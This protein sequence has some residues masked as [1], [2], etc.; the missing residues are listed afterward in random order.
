MARRDFLESDVDHL[1]TFL[2]DQRARVRDAASSLMEVA[3]R[4]PGGLG[5]SRRPLL[6]ASDDDVNEQ[7]ESSQGEDWADDQ[8]A[9]AEQGVDTEQDVAAEQDVVVDSEVSSQDVADEVRASTASTLD[10][11][12]ASVVAQVAESGDVS[13]GAPSFEQAPDGDGPNDD[14]EFRFSFETERN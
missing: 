14:D 9:A 11:D 12:I 5:E 10:D 3:E 13:D 6:S 4:V 7:S 2:V 8:E 1:E